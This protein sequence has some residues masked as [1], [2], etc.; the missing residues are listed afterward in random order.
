MVPKDKTSSPIDSLY[1]N[2][3]IRGPKKSPGRPP[4][5]DPA[6]TQAEAPV[7]TYSGRGSQTIVRKS[8]DLIQNAMSTLTLSQ[9]KLMLHIFAMIKPSDT[10]LP[11]YEMSIYEFLKLCGVEYD[12]VLRMGNELLRSREA[13]DAMAHAVNPYGDGHACARIADAIL[14][15]FGR[16][17]ERPAD[18]NA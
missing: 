4:K 12:D 9:Q 7:A 8:N 5:K 3:P 18:F 11:R 13:Y 15:H 2:A 17:S 6:K 16:R 10:E 14:W 1:P